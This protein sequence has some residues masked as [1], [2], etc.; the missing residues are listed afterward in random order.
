MIGIAIATAATW[1]IHALWQRFFAADST[2][3]LAPVEVVGGDEAT[4]KAYRAGL[5]VMILAATSELRSRTNRAI[6]TLADARTELAQQPRPPEQAE[7]PVPTE[8][9]EQLTINLK[10]AD[11]EVGSLLSWL[12]DRTRDPNLARLTVALGGENRP[13]YVYGVIPGNSGHA[14]AVEAGRDIPAIAQAI[15]TQFVLRVARSGERA[16]EALDPDA[17]LKV[18]ANLEAYARL[19][20]SRQWMLT[21]ADAPAEAERQLR[22]EY[23]R[24]LAEVKPLA[25]RYR[26]WEGLQWLAAQSAREARDWASA[27]EIYAN[28]RSLAARSGDTALQ[29]R[30]AQLADEA[31]RARLAAVAGP[32]ATATPTPLATGPAVRR[33]LEAIGLQQAGSAR[34]VTIGIVGPPPPPDALAGLRREVLAPHSGGEA[35]PGLISYQTTVTEVIRLVAPDA[36]FLYAPFEQGGGVSVSQSRL[37]EAIE[38]LA[39]AKPD[40]LLLNFGYSRQNPQSSPFEHLIRRL[41][42]LGVQV[43]VPAGNDP[44]SPSE[45]SGMTQI[46]LVASATTP[47]GRPAPFTGR[48]EGAIWAPGM[49]IPVTRAGTTQQDLVAGTSYSAA[50]AAGAA[51][52]LK[53]TARDATAAQIHRALVGTSRAPK[54]DGTVPIIHLPAAIA[55]L[56]AGGP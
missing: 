16:F 53:Q 21:G 38:R 52:L 47:E 5:P 32:A 35:D 13:S 2:P 12:L 36:R 46:A 25:L 26:G 31:E 17:F 27:A 45:Y 14:F 3:A 43:V 56:R 54:G 18:I 28:L 51:A 6:R 15:A 40:V 9:R 55:A 44:G 37:L 49:E 24:I 41:A 10:I 39:Q 34:D 42:E 22:E 4:T 8:F 11:V 48:A 19:A 30:V 1:Y 29:A 20:T 23:A 33:V 50:I 7:L